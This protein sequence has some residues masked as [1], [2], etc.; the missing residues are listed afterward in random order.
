[1][2][3]RVPFRPRRHWVSTILFRAQ[4]PDTAGETTLYRE[5]VIKSLYLKKAVSTSI[6]YLNLPSRLIPVSSHTHRPIRSLLYGLNLI[7][8]I[9]NAAI[10]SLC[11]FKSLKSTDAA[12]L[13]PVL[14]HAT[15]HGRRYDLAKIASIYYPSPLLIQHAVHV[16]YN[17]VPF[18]IHSY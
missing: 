1:M 11:A 17:E 8:V 6:R 7:P 13:P 4:Y 15:F 3:V 2:A 10:L 12:V 16:P 9:Y 18:P 5:S 14:A